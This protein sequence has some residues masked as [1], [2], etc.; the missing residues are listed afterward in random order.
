[1]MERDKSLKVANAAAAAAIAPTPAAAA[2]TTQAAAAAPTYIEPPVQTEVSME[3]G[4][5]VVTQEQFD[6]ALSPYGTWIDVEGYGRCWQPTVVVVNP[7]WRPYCDGGRW[8]YTDSGWYWYSDYTWGWA[9]FHY[10]RWLSHPRWGWCWAPDYTWGPAWVTWSYTDTYCGW[11]PLPPAAVYTD[12]G[13]TYCGS[14]VSF[15]FGFGLGYS[16][17]SY[18]PWRYFCDYKPWR[19]CAPRPHCK[20]IYAKATC[21]NDYGRDGNRR[22]VNRGLAPDKV[23]TY[24]RSEIKRVSL[25]ETAPR[26]GAG[27]REEIARD[28]RSLEI[29]RPGA[30]TTETVAG[31][32]PTRTA[33][34]R[35]GLVGTTPASQ[36]VA[37]PRSGQRERP[38]TATHATESTARPAVPGAL[39]NTGRGV[40]IPTR[41]VRSDAGQPLVV[42]GNGDGQPTTPSTWNPYQHSP[43]QRE[44]LASV[45]PAEVEETPA[46]HVAP[47]VHQYNQPAR[48]EVSAP[49]RSQ[50]VRVGRGIEDRSS[51]PTYRVYSS[52]QRPA[53][54]APSY[55]PPPTVNT[56][57]PSRP[58]YS[59]PDSSND[60]NS[61]GSSQRNSRQQSSQPNYEAPRQVERSGQQSPPQRS[62][63]ESRP[64]RAESRPAPEQRSTPARSESSSRSESR[65]AQS[66]SGRSPRGR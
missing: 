52:P 36:N 62:A 27:R 56:P 1:M 18:V 22:V 65:P 58:S 2:T 15:S 51:G 50:V 12:A 25:R 57:A 44:E 29:R 63:P 53:P 48:P 64:A 17:Y 33:T 28:G 21:Y 10:G 55:G 26:T 61:G 41:P 24:T 66:D 40:N 23:A 20:E 32:T 45:S 31:N 19:Y 5:A 14:S 54:S 7:S 42:I 59:Q 30:R 34:S 39:G 11:A 8:I 47:P 46:Q 43:V 38:T 35:S 9:P 60:D 49:Q 4:E 37:A 6:E 16:C 13:F 3:P